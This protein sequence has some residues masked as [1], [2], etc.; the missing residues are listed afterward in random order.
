MSKFF[1]NTIEDF[2]CDPEY[3]AII[4]GVEC[5]TTDES[6]ALSFD[7]EEEAKAAIKTLKDDYEAL[8]VIEVEE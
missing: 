8:I 6:K 1:I 5:I 7:T 3:V 4:N 2:N